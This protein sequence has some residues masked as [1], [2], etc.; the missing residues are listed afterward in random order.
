MKTSAVIVLDFILK[1]TPSTGNLHHVD[2]RIVM[3]LISVV[4]EHTKEL[5]CEPSNTTAVSSY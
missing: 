2:S 5:H 1:S 3:I 4:K